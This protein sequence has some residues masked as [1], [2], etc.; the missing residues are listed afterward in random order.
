[1]FCRW[2]RSDFLELTGEWTPAAH[3]LLK[4]KTVLRDSMVAK[5]ALEAINVLFYIWATKVLGICI[6]KV[7]RSSS[8]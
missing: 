6:I 4:H 3:Y 8:L 1:M 7:L 2:A 5:L